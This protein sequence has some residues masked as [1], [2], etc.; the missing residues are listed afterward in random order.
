MAL[1]V[2]IVLCELC[3][4]HLGAAICCSL[5]KFNRKCEILMQTFLTIQIFA[6]NCVFENLLCSSFFQTVFK[7]YAKSA[8]NLIK[9]QAIELF[10]SLRVNLSIF[11]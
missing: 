3:S 10:C 4:I 2:N 1:H 9:Q 7:F 8:N 11:A 5:F 6:H